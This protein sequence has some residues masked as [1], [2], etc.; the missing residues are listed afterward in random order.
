MTGYFNEVFHALPRQGPGCDECTLKA[1]DQL[2][3]M[4]PNAPAVLDIGCG[5]GASTLCLANAGAGSVM[6]MDRDA[7]LLGLLA[8]RAHAEGLRD[9]VETRECSMF[10]PPFEDAAFDLIWSEGAIYN[11]GFEQGLKTWRRLLRPGGCM[12]I[13]EACW[14]TPDP[15]AE[16][17]KF[18]NAAYPA[19][20]QA[21]G[22][23][24]V[25]KRSGY[26]IIGHFSL[27]A[28]AWTDNYYVPMK[29]QVRLLRERHPG[30]DE[31]EA[32]CTELEQE[33]VMYEQ[34]GTSYG[35]VFFL[36]QRTAN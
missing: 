32:L 20:T 6:G 7:T 9:V 26:D 14:L 11:I 29:E 31:A 23:L 27:P 28:S 25:A 15:P 3:S 21:E 35:Y 34:Y 5:N 22:C 4:L 2:R 10:E 24:T 18:W 1:Y 17:A 33:I 13:T 16:A 19:M 8:K 12:G 30:E 36:L